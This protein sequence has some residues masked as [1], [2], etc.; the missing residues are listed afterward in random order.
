MVSEKYIKA[1]GLKNA[2][3]HGG[4]SVVGAVIAGLFNHGLKKNKIKD[5]M[6]RINKVLS[7]INKLSFGNYASK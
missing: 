2:I 4:K 7:E 3:E 5:E 1:Y 6:P